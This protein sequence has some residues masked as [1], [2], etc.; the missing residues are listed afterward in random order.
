MTRMGRHALRRTTDHSHKVAAHPRLRD[1][2][3][4]AIA[5]GQSLEQ[6]Q[7]G[8]LMDAYKD[9]EFYAQQRPQNVA[10]TYRSL[11]KR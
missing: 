3:A 6:A 11:T 7:A 5:A 8:I 1:A 9:W 4:K 10:G 2:V